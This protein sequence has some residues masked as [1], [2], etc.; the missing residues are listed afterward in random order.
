MGEWSVGRIGGLFESF[1]LYVL[2]AVV[3]IG[4]D[5]GA[6]ILQALRERSSRSP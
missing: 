5:D 6:T 1:F 3:P 4:F 2:Q